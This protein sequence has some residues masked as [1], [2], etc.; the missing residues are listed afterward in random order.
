MAFQSAHDL[1]TVHGDM[2]GGDQWTI[3]VRGHG[4]TISN[5]TNLLAK[6]GVV[7]NAFM[8]M[9]NTLAVAPVSAWTA[10]VTVSGVTCRY[11][12]VNGKTVMQ[13]E[14]LPTVAAVAPATGAYWPNQNAIVVTLLTG[15]A[16]RSGKG[17]VY[18]PLLGNII[19]ADGHHGAAASIATAFSTFL[20][21]LNTGWA[22]LPGSENE[23]AVVGS[24]TAGFLS[25]I[26]GVKVGNVVD[27]QRRRRSSV[28]ETYSSQPV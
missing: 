2:P 15:T 13:Q 27:T 19:A 9:R 4:Q 14:A 25:V 7:S 12:D 11:V 6:G 26:T 22:A 20:K 16:G 8:K 21:D 23:R 3:G 18:L 24:R 5:P 1:F 28:A 17:R 10:G